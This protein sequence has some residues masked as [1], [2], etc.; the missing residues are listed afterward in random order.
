MA[1]TIRSN[2]AS[3]LA[4]HAEEINALRGVLNA[5]PDQLALF[6]TVHAAKDKVTW[7]LGHR[8]SAGHLTATNALAKLTIAFTPTEDA[9][10]AH[11]QDLQDGDRAEG[12]PA[13]IV[14]EV[15]TLLADVVAAPNDQAI[16]VHGNATKHRAASPTK[17]R[18]PRQ[19]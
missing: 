18:N 16:N 17:E 6:A 1:L 13:E 2:N 7:L 3:P 14:A 12:T 4:L 5:N 9:N 11:G 15:L 8:N 10:E 19:A